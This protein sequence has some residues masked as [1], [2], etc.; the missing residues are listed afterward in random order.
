MISP[1]NAIHNNH[2]VLWLVLKMRWLRSVDIGWPNGA[3]LVPYQ[4][5]RFLRTEQEQPFKVGIHTHIPE[6]TGFASLWQDG[7]KVYMMVPRQQRAFLF[8][9]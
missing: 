3:R 5:A 6:C 8:L 9:I 1:M 7:S 2:A 4:L